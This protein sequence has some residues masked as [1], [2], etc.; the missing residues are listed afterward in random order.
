MSNI[1]GVLPK[2]AS[3]AKNVCHGSQSAVRQ[4]PRQLSDRFPAR[5]ELGKSTS[6]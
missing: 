5:P 1:E 4:T 3:A 2:W 6:G